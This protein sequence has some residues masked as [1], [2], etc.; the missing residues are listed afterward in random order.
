MRTID[1]IVLHHTAASRKISPQVDSVI[2]N[3]LKR[4]GQRG[5][6]HFL[7]EPNATV[8]RLRPE[9]EIGYHAG[10]W[11]VNTR[12]IG[13]CLAGDFTKEKPSKEQLDVLEKV[14]AEIQQKYGIADEMIYN[15]REIKS[16][17]CPGI[18]LRRLII[19]LRAT[20]MPRIVLSPEAQLKS[21]ERGANRS[22][23]RVKELLLAGIERLKKRLG[24]K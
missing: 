18:D 13:I 5:A 9:D 24:V 19:E 6:Y 1:R 10:N 21:L 17:A 8:V 2:A 16:T 11:F 23:G 15:H 20:R 12:S 4:L 22:E 14:T 7:I 3:H